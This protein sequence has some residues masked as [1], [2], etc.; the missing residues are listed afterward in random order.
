M[1]NVPHSMFFF[2]IFWKIEVYKNCVWRSKNVIRHNVVLKLI[3]MQH[4]AYLNTGTKTLKPKEA[5]SQHQESQKI[6]FF[7]IF[8][9]W[10]RTSI[11]DVFSLMRPLISLFYKQF[12]HV[13]FR[14]IFHMSISAWVQ[15]FGPLK[16]SNNGINPLD[17]DTSK[18]E[19]IK[20]E[21]SEWL[22]ITGKN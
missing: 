9:T 2:H 1:N 10:D 17:M 16:S 5:E 3:Y 20:L 19:Q 18:S 4:S 12:I 6:G 13:K 7:A 21:I 8:W 22:L 14:L 15:G 11:Q